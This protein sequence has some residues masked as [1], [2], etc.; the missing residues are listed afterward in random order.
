MTK[1]K[2]FFLKKNSLFETHKEIIKK[3]KSTWA[4]S[5]GGEIQI[6]WKKNKKQMNKSKH[7][8]LKK[9]SFLE[10]HKKIIKK[11]KTTR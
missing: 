10:T 9:N 2:H 4:V 5:R 8:F 11:K 6:C 1:S 3:K 7:F